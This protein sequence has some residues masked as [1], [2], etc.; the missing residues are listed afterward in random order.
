M[1]TPIQVEPKG[2]A[3]SDRRFDFPISPY[4][5]NASYQAD[6][7]SSALAAEDIQIPQGFRDT[8]DRLTAQWRDETGMSS[9]ISRKVRHPAYRA[10]IKMNLP[11]VPLILRD[12][13]QR[14]GHWFVALKIITGEN[15][16][17]CAGMTFQQATDA[18]I[19]WGIRRGH[20]AG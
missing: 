6:I 10:I 7:S 9:S 5:P 18:W 20:I 17:Q 8:F 1:T 11:V 4:A 13:Q 14:P 2:T 19:A 12:M 16:V 3:G 15:P